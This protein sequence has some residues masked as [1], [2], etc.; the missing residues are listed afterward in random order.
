MHEMSSLDYSRNWDGMKLNTNASSKTNRNILKRGGTI[1]DTIL[2]RFYNPHMYTPV[3]ERNLR[4]YFNAIVYTPVVT[5][6]NLPN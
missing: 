4:H 6:S 2:N 5:S 1:P 3:T